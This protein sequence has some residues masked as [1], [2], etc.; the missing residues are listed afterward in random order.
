[1]DVRWEV[2]VERRANGEL[3]QLPHAA[4]REAVSAILD[5]C[6]DPF[7]TGVVKLQGYASAYRIRIYHDQYRIVYRVYERKRR[8]DVLRI[9]PRSTAYS[10]MKGGSPRS[11][12]SAASP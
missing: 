12:P 1:M 10:E 5:P 9:R 8:I 7:P 4:R 6:E 11:T 3:K 2:R